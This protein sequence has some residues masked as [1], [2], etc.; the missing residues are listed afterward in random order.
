MSLDDKCVVITGA[1]GGLG[2]TVT[3]AFL[4]AG[5]RVAGVSRSIS[6]S[7][8][9]HAQ[10][11]AVPADVG[12]ADGAQRAMKSALSAFGR[13]DCV[14]HL[15]GGFVSGKTA[16]ESSVDDVERMLDLNYRSAL[17]LSR[18]VLPYFRQ[19]Q[20]GRFAAIGSRVVDVP[21]PM[22]AAYAAS[23]AALVALMRT[24]DLEVSPLGVR[25]RVL[26][27]DTLTEA[28][29]LRVTRELMEFAAS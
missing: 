17:T 10:F 6:D 23:K 15:V 27:P 18:A 13:V 4:A 3:G 11:F 28:E 21:A 2:T 25:A 26:L 8:F 20:A 19:Q 22:T 14:V 24:I 5:A 12:S 7:D 1:K 16:D 9:A 29:S